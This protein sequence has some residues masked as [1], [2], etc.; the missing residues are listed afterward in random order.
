MCEYKKCKEDETDTNSWE[1][2][3]LILAA[4]LWLTACLLPLTIY[5]YILFALAYLVCGLDVL[6]TAAKKLIHAQV[7]EEHFLMSL[8]SLSAFAIGE[9]AEGVGVMWFYQLG[10]FLM[11]RAQHRSRRSVRALLDITPQTAWVERERHWT[12]VPAASVQVGETILVKAGQRVPLDGIILNGETTLDTAALTGES[13]PRYVQPKEQVLAG[14]IVLEGALEICVTHPF[15]DSAISKILHLVEHAYSQKTPS[16][17]FITR[18][19]RWYTPCVVV[20]AMGVALLPPMFLPDASLKIW[21]YRALIFLVISCPCALVLSVPLGFL[22]GIGAAAK[23][24]ILIKGSNSLEGL[25]QGEIFALDKTGTLTQGIFT[26]KKVV[27]AGSFSEQ[28]L[29]QAAAYAESISTH[30]LARAI[31]RAYPHKI[32]KQRIQSSHEKAGCGV[33]VQVDHQEIAVGQADFIGVSKEQIGQPGETCVWVRIDGQYA[34]RITF[35]DTLKQDSREAIASLKKINFTRTVLL[36]GDSSQ[37]ATQMA[38]QAGIEEVHASLLPAD[39]L[40]WIEQLLQEKQ[41][42]RTVLFA[43]DGINDAPVLA[44]ADVGIA[45]GALG[46]DAAVQAADVV[47]VDDKLSKIAWGVRLGRFTLQIVKQNIWF[48]LGVKAGVM[49]LGVIG[50]ATLWEAVFADV[51]VAVL[52]VFNSLRPLGYK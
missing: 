13:V 47:L 9:Y 40:Y 21:V 17:R 14:M 10:E 6:Q 28:E 45:M 36:T 15:E 19:A 27:P 50:A 33:T 30:P 43:G 5:R 35:T 34:G 20:A 3:R 12:E 18:F 1:W 49:L 26:V 25:A 42:G 44:A 41:P 11:E 52:C 39:K 4:V 29:W 48:A 7:L 46:A 24:G 16:E 23:Q 51:G 32:D 38:V 2:I 37:A 8:A 22:G 31:V